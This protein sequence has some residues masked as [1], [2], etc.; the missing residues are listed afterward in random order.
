MNEVVVLA[1]AA[2]IYCLASASSLGSSVAFRCGSNFV[3]V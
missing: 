1:A 3:K 2:R